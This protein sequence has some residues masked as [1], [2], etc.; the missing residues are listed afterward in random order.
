MRPATIDIPEW[1]REVLGE[2]LRD[3]DS[4]PSHSFDQNAGNR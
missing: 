1:Q 2:R 4:D 3:L